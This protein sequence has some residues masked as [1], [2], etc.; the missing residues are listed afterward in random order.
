MK[1]RTTRK[2]VANAYGVRGQTS[3]GKSTDE[4]ELIAMSASVPRISTDARADSN[5]VLVACIL[6]IFQRASPSL[7]RGG[8]GDLISLQ[9][10]DVQDNAIVARNGVRNIGS[11]ARV[12]AV[13]INVTCLILP[14]L[15]GVNSPAL[16]GV[17]SALEQMQRMTRRVKLRA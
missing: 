2:E 17:D 4:F 16:E 6:V 5:A 10:V 14:A 1:L 3:S 8:K 12:E 11:T 9:L 13:Q 7:G 15:E